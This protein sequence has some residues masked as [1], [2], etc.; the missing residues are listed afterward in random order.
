MDVHMSNKWL[1]RRGTWTGGVWCLPIISLRRSSGDFDSGG[2][3]PSE[4]EFQGRFGVS[5]MTVRRALSE[6]VNEGPLIREQDRG[7]FVVNPDEV[8]VREVDARRW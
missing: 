6:L 3:F 5:R 8:V 7:S 4:S 1:G 2:R